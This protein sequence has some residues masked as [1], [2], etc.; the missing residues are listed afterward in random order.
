MATGKLHQGTKTIVV[1]I[2]CIKIFTM[3]MLILI[4]TMGYTQPISTVERAPKEYTENTFTGTLLINSQTT[5]VLQRRSWSFGIQHRF[6]QVGL[7][8]TLVQ[9]F[10]GLDLPSIV[11]FSF[12]RALSD[13]LSFEIGR[14]NHLKTVD[15]EAKY[16]IA[17]QTTDFRMPVSIAVYFNTAV[18]TERFPRVPKNA[19][20]QDDTTQFV[21]KPSYRFVYNTQ[22]VI[23]SKLSDRIS[24]QVNPIFIYQNLVA[25]HADNFTLVLSGGG[26]FK[27]GLSSA[28]IAEYAYVFN[29]RSNQFQ[30]PFSAGVEFG[31][32]GHTFQVFVS[33]ASRILESQIYTASATNISDGEFL[34][35]F[36]LKRIFW[37]RN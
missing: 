31:T 20:Y 26:R 11:R 16:L 29:N 8:S 5:T 33:T 32:A 15:L 36:N 34:I 28:F 6:G 9:Q 18:R 22:L 3:H 7:D 1:D 2:L 24:I 21:Y 35:G 19:Y 25:P 23:S 30:D 13:R 10:L 37:R 4:S 27:L 12:S 14:T 17:K